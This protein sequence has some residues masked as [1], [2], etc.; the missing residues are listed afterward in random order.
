MKDLTTD[1][2]ARGTNCTVKVVGDEPLRHLVILTPDG[3]EGFFIDLAKG[4][5]R[6]PD[7]MPRDCGFCKAPPSDLHWSCTGVI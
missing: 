1:P 5:F 3:F 6:S 7:D 2:D 4:Q